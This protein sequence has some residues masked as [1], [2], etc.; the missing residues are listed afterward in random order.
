M[1]PP[2][3][4]QQF[5]VWELVTLEK[6]LRAYLNKVDNREWARQLLAKLQKAEALH[7]T[8]KEINK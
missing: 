5:D 6:A 2:Q 3:P 8:P 4:R 1:K 7:F